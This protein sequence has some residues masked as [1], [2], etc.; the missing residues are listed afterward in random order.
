MSE[1]VEF[2][3]DPGQTPSPGQ[4]V[5]RIGI[6]SNGAANGIVTFEAGQVGLVDTIG[7]GPLPATTRRGLR[8]GKQRSVCV[9]TAVD[10]LGAIS[11]VTQTGGG[12]TVVVTAKPAADNQ[13]EG[14]WFTFPK[15]KL[16]VIAKGDLGAARAQFFYDGITP[17]KETVDLAPQRP[18]GLIGD[19]D[20][21]GITLSA[22]N[23]LTFK[24]TPDGGTEQTTTFVTPTDVANIATQINATLANSASIVAGR[25]LKIIGATLGNAGLLEIGAG[26]ANTILGFSADDE[27]EG[28]DSTFEPSGTGVVFTFPAGDYEEETTYEVAT[29]APF[30]AIADFEAAATALRASG[31]PFS[32][33]HVVYEPVDGIDLLAWQS[34][35]ESFRITLATAEDNPLFFKWVLGGPMAP[36]EDWEATDQDVKTALFGTQEANKFNTIPYGDIFIEWQEYTGRHRTQLANPY[37]ERMQLYPMNI[38]PGLGSAGGLENCYLNDLDGARARVESEALVKMQNSGFSVLRDDRKSPYIR[39][40]RTR[41]PITSQLTGEQT[42]R[43]ALECARIMRERAFYY[44]NFTPGLAKN[45]Q[46]SATDEKLIL[47]KFNDDL[48]AGIVGPGYASSAKVVITGFTKTGGGNKLFVKGIFQRLGQI[49]DV[50]LI[51]YV[52]DNV[53]IVEGVA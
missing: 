8:Y 34:A 9:L 22:L 42:T 43:A 41:A 44:A 37:V 28:V 7:F 17:A 53:E 11:A 39:A 29:V 25:Y 21:T 24:W 1:S 49:E 52:T 14:P 32:I 51:V 12:P 30:M 26:T 15:M 5:A 50:S 45:G 4:I 48:A 6:A 10:T 31:E 18:A 23:T 38:N 3:E 13:I 36:V 46:L 2:R 20:L 40:G 35:L 27:A 47:G 33:L 16:K 19:E